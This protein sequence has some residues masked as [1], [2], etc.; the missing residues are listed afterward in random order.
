MNDHLLSFSPI[1]EPEYCYL[2]M[3]HYPFT[4]LVLLLQS[5]VSTCYFILFHCYFFLKM[6][7]ECVH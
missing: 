2:F 4:M 5:T 7:V 6:L 1:Y 3:F